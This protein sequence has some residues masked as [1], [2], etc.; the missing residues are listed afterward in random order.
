MN[1]PSQPQCIDKE[2]GTSHIIDIT[3]RGLFVSSCTN[4]TFH[5]TGKAIK[6][7]FSGCNNCTIKIDCSL[8]TG[9]TEIINSKDLTVTILADVPTLQIDGSSQIKFNLK[10]HKH[11][12]NVIS[13]QCSDISFILTNDNNQSTTHTIRLPVSKEGDVIEGIP[14]YIT[15]FV[16]D[17]KT[18]KG[19]TLSTEQVVREGCGYATTQRE[20]AIADARDARYEE[21]LENYLKNTI[22]EGTVE[23]KPK[24]GPPSARK[25]Q[26]QEEKAARVVPDFTKQEEEKEEKAKEKEEEKEEDVKEEA[27]EHKGDSE[28]KAVGGR[29]IL[30]SEVTKFK[31]SRLKKS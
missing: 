14:Q 13:S 26:G 15:R 27:N 22:K 4:C 16:D 18:G 6:L 20:K 7:A 2:N 12:K 5:L 17:S 31:K 1:G 29:G 11:L 3:R 30:L 19:L 21:V 10:D 28:S 23:K 24:F 9:I 8:I 25:Q